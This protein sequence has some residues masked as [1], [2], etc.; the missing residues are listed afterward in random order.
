M[1]LKGGYSFWAI[2]NGLMCVLSQLKANIC[3]DVVVIGGGITGALIADELGTN[4]F[5][6]VVVKQRDIGW[7]S[8]AAST[9]LL[10]Y[11]IDTHL[12]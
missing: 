2:K 4:D 9:A 12:V 10:Q 8:S 5:D 11:E 3:C 7:G 6:V 1:D